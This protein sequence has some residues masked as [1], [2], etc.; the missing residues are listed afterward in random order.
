[1]PEDTELQQ[2][3]ADAPENAPDAP[4]AE[5]PAQPQY[6]QFA[7]N[8]TPHGLM[9][10]VMPAPVQLGIGP[11]GMDEICENWVAQRPALAD[12]LI[13]HRVEA[14]R[15]AQEHLQIVRDPKAIKSITRTKNRA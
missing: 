12:K 6:P 8:L 7:V 5:Q 14:R 4:Q 2:P 13:Q 3:A 10:G 1:M 11:D 15:K 9:V